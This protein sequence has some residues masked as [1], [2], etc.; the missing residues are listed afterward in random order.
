MLPSTVSLSFD[1]SIDSSGRARCE[2]ELGA[3]RRQRAPHAWDRGTSSR[4]KP[5][6]CGAR[7]SSSMA[8]PSHMDAPMSAR[9]LPLLALFFGR[10]DR[11]NAR[12][13]ELCEF[14]P[15]SGEQEDL[16][17]WFVQLV[18]WL[19]PKRGARADAK[20]RFLRTHL[21][22]HAAWRANV[23]GAFGD[24][25][26][27]A[28]VEELLAYGGIPVHFHFGGA[29]KEWLVV[30][31]LPA[32]CRTTDAA[33]I[34]RLAFEERDVEWLASDELVPLLRVLLDDE[35]VEALQHGLREALVNL[36]HQIVAQAHSPTVKTLAHE[37]RSPFRGLYE[38]VLALNADPA[39]K[40]A[41]EGLRGRAK[42]CLLHLH[43]HRTE[44]A[45]RGA[46]LNTTFQLG[47]MREQLE[48]LSLLAS[49]RHDP[50]DAVLAGSITALIGSVT[51]ASDGKR[52]VARSADLLVQNIVD[53]AATVG[54]K[55]LGDEQSSWRAAFLAGAG[56]GVLMALATVLKFLIAGLHLPHLY[57]GLAF[58][59]NYGSAFCAAFLLH[60][61]IATKLPAHTAAALARSV[62]A[63]GGHRERLREFVGV[64]RTMLR[65]QIAGLVGNVIV[66]GPLAF[67]TDVGAHRVFGHHLLSAEKA[68]HVL[69][70]HS[71]LGPSLL[72]AA[73]TGLFLWV[74][75]LLG[76]AGDNWTRVTHLADRL[77]TN[78]HVMKRIGAA[79]AE[80]YAASV[81]K[82]FGGLLGNLSLGFM[83]GGIPAAFAI[84]QLPVEI[85]HVTVSTG[86]VALALAEGAGTRGEIALAVGGVFVIAIVNVVVSFV[87]AL[88]LALRATRGMRTSSSANALV[89]IG[90]RGA[91][92]G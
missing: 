39:G 68:E 81:E 32:A 62:Q 50:A 8:R 89:R 44:L 33:K 19:R 67:L 7:G 45:A 43:G 31:I 36:A 34:L 46:D 90:I 76:A 83:L 78:V 6:N 35:L 37:E 30:R 11:T 51:R 58:S 16:V 18:E 92:G 63:T 10:A 26:R 27:H 38:A 17:F 12:L 49:L 85:R 77:A 3:L 25:V 5:R 15:R 91:R 80:R 4:R 75:S 87:L 65:L 2:R 73:L 57:E 47:R 74:S 29:V 14:A 53:A 59:L 82:R 56:G 64:W 20:L 84:A 9:R 42:Q 28:D 70:A 23:S 66:V 86:S 24:L 21:E 1:S 69:A 55:Y 22:T 60:F 54:R 88:W 71:V 41:F 48:R 52:L 72:Y 40:A 79:R 61:T 13:D